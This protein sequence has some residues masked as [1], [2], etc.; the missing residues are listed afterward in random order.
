M[1]MRDGLYCY[2]L[3]NLRLDEDGLATLKFRYET[4]RSYQCSAHKIYDIYSRPTNALKTVVGVRNR[5]PENP[6]FVRVAP[7]ASSVSIKFLK[8]KKV[9]VQ[10]Y[11]VR[12]SIS[13]LKKL[14]D[15]QCKNSNLDVY[16]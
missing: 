6:F 7:N 10:S 9:R 16:I 11:R 5:K 13:K 8:G 14:I 15:N 12:S 1:K 3:D 2:V 4:M